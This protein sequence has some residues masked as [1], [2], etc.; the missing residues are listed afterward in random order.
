MHEQGSLGAWRNPD[1]LLRFL[2]E[3]QPRETDRVVIQGQLCQLVE[4]VLGT[5]ALRKTRQRPLQP[6]L[7]AQ[8]ARTQLGFGYAAAGT[9]VSHGA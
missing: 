5:E 7:P 3:I 6:A 8:D 4:S 2:K 1:Q 9:Q